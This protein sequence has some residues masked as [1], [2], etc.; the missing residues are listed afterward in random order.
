[1]YL[2]SLIVFLPNLNGVEF[3]AIGNRELVQTAVR[4]NKVLFRKEERPGKLVAKLYLV[5]MTVAMEM[6]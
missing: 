1:M 5:C 4:S 3:R 2:I 6:K